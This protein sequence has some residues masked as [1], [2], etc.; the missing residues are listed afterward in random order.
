MQF[1]T[2]DHRR[3]V[4]FHLKNFGPRF[5]FAYRLTDKTV[6]RGAYALMYGP[7][8]V[9]AA[10]TSGSSGTEGFQSSTGMIVSTDNTNIL[11]NLSNPFPNGFN[12]PL[13]SKE[14]PTSGA[15]TNLGLGI[16]ETFFI[17]PPHPPI[18][19]SNLNLHLALT[20]LWLVSP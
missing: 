9:Q 17:D 15:S 2:P 5:G 11:A 19:Q 14:G 3:Q 13:G 20:T 6:F 16:G 10:G 8:V 4:P 7:S 12:L 1:V 18:Q